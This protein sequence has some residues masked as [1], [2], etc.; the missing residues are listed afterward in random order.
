M[1]EISKIKLY[2]PGRSPLESIISDYEPI[3]YEIVVLLNKAEMPYGRN[4][5][6][7][8]DITML[9]RGRVYRHRG[10]ESFIDRSNAFSTAISFAWWEYAKNTTISGP[11]E[12]EY[13]VILQRIRSWLLTT[14]SVGRIKRYKAWESQPEMIVEMVTSATLQKFLP[15]GIS[16]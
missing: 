3:S 9:V 11:I 12:G 14:T 6:S 1:D 8:A 7:V 4:F 5:W 2:C 10:F 16:A 13:W 15:F